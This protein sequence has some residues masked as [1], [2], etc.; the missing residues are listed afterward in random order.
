MWGTRF[1]SGLATLAALVLAAGCAPAEE[2]GPVVLAAASMQEGLTA[3]ANAWEAQGQP[4]PVVSFASSAAVARQVGE[5]GPADLV[6]IA[7]REWIDWLEAREALGSQ[8][9][10]LVT[11]GLVVVAPL[12]TAGPDSLAELAANPDAGRL[13]MGEPG[14]VPAGKF[15]RVA[16]QSMG[17]WEALAPR[18]VPGDNVRVSL[19][20]VERGEVPLGIVYASDA[21]ASRNVRVVQRI[22]PDMHPPIIYYLARTRS[23][24]H[25]DAQGFADFLASQQGRAII[26]GHGF[27]WP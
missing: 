2:A 22:D 20:L 5:G 8:P 14:S 3:A 16:L 10:A 13:A 6:V 7:D 21:Q 9:R 19:A 17:L 26:A 4:A 15:A 24:R 11:N 12:E 1:R 27:G 23:S 18:V 25:P